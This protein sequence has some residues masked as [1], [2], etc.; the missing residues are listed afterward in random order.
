MDAVSL[1]KGFAFEPSALASHRLT[2]PI[3]E[4]L[5]SRAPVEVNAILVPSGDQVAA[6][7][8]ATVYL[9]IGVWLEPSAFIVQILTVLFKA[10]LP[11]R[12]RRDTQRILAPSGDH[13]GKELA[14]LSTVSFVSALGAEP[15][16]FIDHMLSVKFVLGASVPSKAR[17]DWK[18][19]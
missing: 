5:P 18:A 9:V 13:W 3:E 6:N 8:K 15:S 12:A 17:D 16:G 7:A 14:A 2:A 19:M 4:S 11:S 1:V 10:S